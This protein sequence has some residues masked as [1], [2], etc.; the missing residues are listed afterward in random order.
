VLNVSG[1]AVTI[2]RFIAGHDDLSISRKDV[3]WFKFVR[4]GPAAP[5]GALSPKDAVIALDRG[6]DTITVSKLGREYLTND[7]A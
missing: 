6:V 3:G 2:T 4:G 7:A 1:N 5:K